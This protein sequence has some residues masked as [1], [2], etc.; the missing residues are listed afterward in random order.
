[1][2]EID[3][4]F[5]IND[6]LSFPSISMMVTATSSLEILIRSAILIPPLA[7]QVEI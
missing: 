6:W 4:I 5:F 2:P 3:I 7:K 1:M